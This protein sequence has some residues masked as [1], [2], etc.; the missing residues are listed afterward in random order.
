MLEIAYE[1][2]EVSCTHFYQH[3]LNG[4]DDAH[5]F[6][7]KKD[8]WDG[9]NRELHKHNIKQQDGLVRHG[10]FKCDISDIP[11]D[12]SIVE[13]TLHL[14]IHSREG[15]IRGACSIIG[16][17]E[18]KKEWDWDYVDWLQYDDGLPWDA[19]GGDCGVKIKD[20]WVIE[21]IR[22]QGYGMTINQFP[23]DLT[24]CVIALQHNRIMALS[25]NTP[26]TDPSL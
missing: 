6:F 10:L 14:H 1:L 21:D 26:E 9:D 4:L 8:G 3:G 16:F 12:A 22:N 17:F 11:L 25:K 2:E 13:A 23:L 24:D 20:L 19:E 7:I 15:L 18:C 5:G